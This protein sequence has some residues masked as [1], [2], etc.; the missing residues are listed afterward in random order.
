MISC[1]VQ[2]T[3]IDQHSQTLTAFSVIC[4]ICQ[5]FQNPYHQINQNE[6]NSML[7]CHHLHV[8]FA[9]SPHC[10]FFYVALNQL[11]CELLHD[12]KFKQMKSSDSY[13]EVL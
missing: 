6:I 3:F 13:I 2:E 10:L 8:F 7:Q 12:M 11:I 1:V 4:K 5:F 9:A